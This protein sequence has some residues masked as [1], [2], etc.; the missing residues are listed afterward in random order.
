MQ[1]SLRVLESSPRL[2][3]EARDS[4]GST[5]YSSRGSMAAE[6]T[7]TATCPMIML[8]RSQVCTVVV[9]PPRARLRPRAP[10]S[11][12]RFDDNP[13]L[14]AKSRPR[15]PHDSARW[16]AAPSAPSRGLG[17]HTTPRDGR[18]SHRSGNC[19]AE[20]TALAT[21]PLIFPPSPLPSDSSGTAAYPRPSD[22]WFLSFHQAEST[23]LAI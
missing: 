1:H 20:T 11:W 23:A 9:T 16:A 6:D 18:Q 21:W 5:M 7:P 8:T 12:A 15:A 4:L 19:Q 13:S 2:T 17:H 3:E 10:H 22:E 14:F